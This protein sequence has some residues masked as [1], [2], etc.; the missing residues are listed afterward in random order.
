MNKWMGIG[1]FGKDPELSKNTSG[2]SVCKFSLAVPR[3]YKEEG[4][5][6][7]DWINFVAWNSSAEFISKYFSK[8]DAIYIEG[9]LQAHVYEGKDGKQHKD[10]EI[11][12]ENAEFLPGGR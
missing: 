6:D 4:K 11:I 10:F 8:G 2:K 9:E 7:T 1:R 5:P 3:T 12:V